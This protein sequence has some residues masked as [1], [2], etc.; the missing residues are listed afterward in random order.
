[1]VFVVILVVILGL[2]GYIAKINHDLLVNKD[3]I[4][5]SMAALD[6]VIIKKNNAI[7]DVLSYAQEVVT[8]E[9]NLVNELFNLRHDI[10]KIKPKI[11]NA[12]MRY[13]KQVEFDRKIQ[14]FLSVCSRYSELNKNSSF[15]K[16]LVAYQT[17]EEDF[18]AKVEFFNTC[19]DNLNW[20]IHSF[21]SSIL[22]QMANTKEPPEKYQL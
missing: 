8:K 20:S 18:K 12:P 15:Q 2:I 6:A 7:L 3:N 10:N 5:R 11:A 4:L 21:P 14:T 19:I 1:M 13:Q 22:A 9:A 17:L 16:S